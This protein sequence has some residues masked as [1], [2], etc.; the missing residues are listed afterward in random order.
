MSP[1]PTRVALGLTLVPF[2]ALG[3]ARFAYGLLLPPMRAD[4]G[5]TYGAAGAVT[6]AN[7]V[8]YLIGALAAAWSM[9]RFGVRHSVVAATWA[10]GAAL[11]ANGA[12][13]AYAVIL[14]SR[15]AAGISGGVAF[16]S[17]S[18]LAAQLSRR[19]A[20]RALVWYPAG[21][22]AAIAVS[23]VT[24]PGLIEPA[25]SWPTGWF[26]LA[27]A[28]AACAVIVGR[29]L[30]HE[31]DDEQPTRPR[32]GN[33]ST[34]LPRAEVAYGLFGLGYIAYITFVVAYLRDGGASAATIVG[35][36]FL[37]G[38]ASVVSTQVWPYV[39]R[40]RIGR[41]GL[42]LT[43]AG[44]AL[45]VVVAVI[46]RSVV[47]A[48]LSALL[49][50]ASFLAVVTAIAELARDRVPE[51]SWPAALARLTIIFGV[52]QVLGPVLAG[53]LGDSP[54]GLRLGLGFSAATLTLAA[55]V[56][57]PART[58]LRTHRVP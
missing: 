27:A 8:G 30:R 56:A 2:V 9:H 34:R 38:A 54:A 55:I 28:S 4:L 21:A 46:S 39:T 5:W 41:S 23:A 22:G 58:S 10:T 48:A 13:G 36:W 37:L 17:G 49:F 3:L 47:M 31:R 53:L 50:G 20:G 44:C 25:S 57:V 16:V 29:L 18:V 52:G 33:G 24:V 6:T 19:G 7:A 14:L 43:L 1:T 12:T 45:A 26:V 42:A 11:L 40:T 32:S 15:L 51:A 35:F